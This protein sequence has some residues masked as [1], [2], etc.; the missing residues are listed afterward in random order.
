MAGVIDLKGKVSRK[1]NPQRRSPQVVLLVESKY[2][3]VIQELCR[4]TGT[5]VE[6]H[7]R[8]LDRKDWMRRNCSEHCAEPHVHV[9]AE[10]LPSLYRWT[11][12]GMGMVVVVHNLLP[13]LR[14]DP[15]WEMLMEEAMNSTTT[16]GRGSMAVITSLRRLRSLGW[17][18]PEEV[19]IPQDVQVDTSQI[20]STQRCP[21]L[22]QDGHQCTLTKGHPPF[23]VP[24]WE[25]LNVTQ[26]GH[27]FER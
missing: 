4:L 15:G 9:E 26:E 6:A 20:D 13:F 12:T 14:T 18:F 16:E 25:G 21:W 8:P 7:T 5:R 3:A 23:P 11:I 17:E 19:T 2:G 1:N 24:V 10:N 27:V 22:G